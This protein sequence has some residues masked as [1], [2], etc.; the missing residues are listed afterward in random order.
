MYTATDVRK[1]NKRLCISHRWKSFES[2]E[3][4]V[5]RKLLVALEIFFY[6]V[7]KFQTFNLLNA[8]VIKDHVLSKKMI[9]KNFTLTQWWILPNLLL[10]VSSERKNIYLKIYIYKV[11]F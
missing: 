5:A 9:I 7:V 11:F 2:L 1:F 8:V 4:S 6:S 10:A 3:L